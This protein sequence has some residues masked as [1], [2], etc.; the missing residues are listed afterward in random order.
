MAHCGMV[1][2]K[3]LL[4]MGGRG[5]LEDLIPNVEQLELAHFPFKGWIIDP[6]FHG[7]LVGPG[8]TVHLPTH[9]GEI[10]YT[11]VVT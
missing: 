9:Y 11:E 3:V 10:V 6:D 7:L 4:E 5:I 2:A 8:N 1:T